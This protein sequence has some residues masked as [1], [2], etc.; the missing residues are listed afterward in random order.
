MK[1]LRQ[2]K[3]REIV[4]THVVETQEDLAEHLRRAHIEVT[5]ATVS[6]DIKELRLVKAPMGGGRSRYA[7]PEAGGG[8]PQS[9]LEGFFTDAVTGADSSG[10]LVVLRTLPGMAN[11]VASELDTAEWPEVIGTVA[12]DDTILVVVKP[13]AA[14]PAVL[15]RAKELLGGD[16]VC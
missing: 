6:R 9:R 12:G 3:I 15:Q 11:A 10:N 2:E 1:P 13:E 5:Q 8:R 4:E 7:F 16:A 14:A